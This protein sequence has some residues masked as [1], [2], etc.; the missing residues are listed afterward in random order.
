M[1]LRRIREFELFSEVQDLWRQ[2]ATDSARVA[3]MFLTVLVFVAPGYAATYVVNDFGDAGDGVCDASCTLRDA[4]TTANGT[5]DNDVIEFS[6]TGLITLDETLG[7]IRFPD[8]VISGSLKIQGPEDAED[9]VIEWTTFGFFRASFVV[10]A[11]GR[12]EFNSISIKNGRFRMAGAITNLGETVVDNCLLTENISSDSG[13]G[14]GGA[15]RNLIGATMLIRKTRIFDNFADSAGAIRNDGEMIVRDSI[16]S[17]NGVFASAG[18]IL[19]FG[20]IAIERSTISENRLGGPLQGGGL[21]NRGT[22]IVTNSTISGNTGYFSSRPNKGGGIYNVGILRINNTTFSNNEVGPRSAGEPGLGGGIYNEDPGRVTLN[23]SIIANSSGGAEC[24]NVGGKISSFNSLIEDSLSCVNDVLVASITGDPAL[25][26]LA[27]N[28]GITLTHALLA[29]SIALDAGDNALIPPG[30]TTDQRFEARIFNGTVDMGSFESKQDA[31]GDG[32]LD[33]NDVC[34]ATSLPDPQPTL[35]LRK[36]RYIA[37]A[38]GEFVDNSGN[39]SGIRVQD[40]GGC[41]GAQVIVEA[42][43]GEGHT[44]FGITRSALLDWIEALP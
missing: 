20:E 43:L 44:R 29:G 10:E 30:V 17:G 26:P 3:A 6:G 22:M 38:N 32:V 9:L 18:G 1:N 19:N 15:I 14:H 41:S 42:G 37:S 36:N 27:D 31:D 40:T 2:R 11:G 16:I 21:F 28:G 34:P 39:S 7:T 8:S 24:V 12:V 35:G 5:L 13:V 23:N 33:A 25:G 4:I